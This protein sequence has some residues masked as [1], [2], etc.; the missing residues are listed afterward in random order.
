MITLRRVTPEAS[1]TRRPNPRCRVC[2]ERAFE[3]K[4]Y[5][6]EHIEAL[7]YPARVMARVEELSAP[8]EGP[9][10]PVCQELLLLISPEWAPLHCF[11]GRTHALPLRDVLHVLLDAGLI[12]GRGRILERPAPRNGKGRSYVRRAR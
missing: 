9:E 10:H 3:G 12:E 4:P 8:I 7:P 6:P 5:C 1:H 11:S 2:G